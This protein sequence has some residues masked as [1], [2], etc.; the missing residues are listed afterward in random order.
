M[1]LTIVLLGLPTLAS[2]AS[3]VLAAPAGTEPVTEPDTH[4]HHH[5]TEVPEAA[6]STD[7][8]R[9]S[10]DASL[11]EGMARI[12]QATSKATTADPKTVLALADE[13]GA[14]VQF[15]IKHCKLEPE[16]DATLHPLLARLLQTS[17]ELR[18]DPSSGAS[19]QVVVDTWAHIASCSTIPTQPSSHGNDP[20]LLSLRGI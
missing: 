5:S 19:I 14:S 1:C 18:K 9:W 13:I 16:A 2:G 4:D 17:A 10:T 6:A 7:G 15:M 3:E 11:R 12:Q 8:K 20:G